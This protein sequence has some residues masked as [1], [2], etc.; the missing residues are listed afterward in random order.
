M[1]MDPVKAM[2]LATQA[3]QEAKLLNH[4]MPV[5]R[6]RASEVGTCK[7]AIW[8]R[9]KGYIPT[10]FSAR[11]LDFSE[12]GDMHHDAV[13]FKLKEAGVKFD[14][15]RFN[16]DG[17]VDELA[18]GVFTVKHTAPDGEKFE[19]TFSWRADGE[20][21]IGTTWH[22]LEIKSIGSGDRR[23]YQQAWHSGSPDVVLGKMMES[24]KG[25]GYIMQC[26]VV[27]EGF[28]RNLNKVRKKAYL[29]FKDRDYC[30]IGLH[31]WGRDEQIVG[32]PTIQYTKSMWTQICN[33]M[34]TV[35]RGLN[36]NVPPQPEFLP[37]SKECK[38]NCNFLHLC[39]GAD[40]RAKIDLPP[41]HPTLGDILH[42]KD[43]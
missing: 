22:V 7:R 23:I 20:I 17:T 34:A 28:K 38:N 39:H 4:K 40:K 12:D 36:S 10:A 27:M 37:S 9:L 11:G 3:K 8:Y 1:V 41:C 14:S 13:R 6:F 16:K 43:L 33:R 26:H 42:V 19:L 18:D 31:T 30:A 5:Q 25:M 32:G 15:L 2:Y 29:L 21:R 35:Q 24:S